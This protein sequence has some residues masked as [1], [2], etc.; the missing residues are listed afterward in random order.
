[1]LTTKPQSSHDKLPLSGELP[2]CMV[3]PPEIEDLATRLNQELEAIAAIATR[4]LEQLEELL[5]RFPD[6]QKLI[7]LFAYFNSFLFF[8]TKVKADLRAI[9]QH[10]SAIAA[11]PEEIQE[12]GEDLSMRLTQA[13]ESRIRVETTL[14]NLEN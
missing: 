3:I 13:I 9:E 7:Q 2:F 5:Q 4:G 14:R 6:N 10:L 11:T 1:M 12:I 8:T